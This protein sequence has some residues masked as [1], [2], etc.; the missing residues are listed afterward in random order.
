MQCTQRGAEKDE[1]S[2][3]PKDNTVIY[4]LIYIAT[5]VKM[6]NKFNC[7]GKLHYARQ[8]LGRAAWRNQAECLELRTLHA[9]KHTPV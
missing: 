7:R 2:T 4:I 1:E 5:V 3:I 9:R 8:T 6:N